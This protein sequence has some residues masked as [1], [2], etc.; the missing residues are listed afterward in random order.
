MLKSRKEGIVGG[1]VTLGLGAFLAK[2]IGAVYRIPLTN[3]IGAKG[4]GLYQTVFPVYTLLL[5][6]SGAGVPSAISKIISSHKG[7]DKERYALQY[8]KSSLLLLSV[9]G[10][11]ASLAM[12]VLANPLSK[13]QGN[14]EARYSYLTLAPAIFF[15]CVLSCFRGYFQGLMNMRPTAISQIIEQTIKL[16]LGLTFVGAFMPDITLASAGATLAITLSEIVACVYFFILYRRKIKSNGLFYF[17]RSLFL[18]QA[19][20]I[21]KTTFPIALIGVMIPL[22]QVID[23]VL[24][25]NFISSYRD[26]ATALYG[27]FSGAVATVINLPVSVCYGIAC[28]AIPA[29]SAESEEGE[30]K[31]KTKKILLLTLAVALPSA[32]LVG[33]FSPLAVKILFSRMS[34]GE[35][36]TAVSLLRL[37]AP[38]VLLLSLLQTLNGVLVG[39]NRLYAPVISLSV[40]IITKT[41][42]SVILLNIP[43]VN[44]FGGGIALIACYLVAVLIN[45]FMIFTK[46]V[47]TCKLKVLKSATK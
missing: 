30:N 38:N 29:I 18:P 6:F 42:I 21:V 7:E 43:S 17:E 19:K 4:L 27:I 25:V 47:K 41:V 10:A 3:L 1:A 36:S 12:A 20:K 11:I 23:S 46:R 34:D 16:I 35:K 28:V 15:V 5:D 31:R 39:R 22:S 26:D 13:I 44:I 45:L 33:V 32:I 37:C 40:G 14:I 8:L 9:L 2:V 24:I